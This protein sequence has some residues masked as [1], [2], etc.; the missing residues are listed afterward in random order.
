MQSAAGAGALDRLALSSP[1][2]AMAR[3]VGVRESLQEWRPW[4]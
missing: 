2:N 1:A 3:V 4:T